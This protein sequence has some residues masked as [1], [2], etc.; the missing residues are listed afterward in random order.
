[1]NPHLYSPPFLQLQAKADVK[2]RDGEGRTAL[3]VAV[4]N[5]RTV[6]IYTCIWRK[7]GTGFFVDDV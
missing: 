3:H 2:D 4:Q 7:L 6:C 5:A 1:M